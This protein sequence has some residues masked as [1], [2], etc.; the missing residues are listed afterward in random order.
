MRKTV[1]A[2]VMLVS[3]AS[4]AAAQADA[5]VFRLYQGAQELGREVFQDDGTTLRSTVT[6]PLLTTKLVMEETRAGGRV[7]RA[8]LRALAL[9]ADT[10]LRTYTATVEGDSVRLALVPVTGEARRWAKPGQPDGIGAEQSVASI[11]ALIQK[12]GRRDT[13]WRYWLPSADSVLQLQ[14]DFTG[15]SVVVRLASQEMFA[16]LGPDGRVQL[17]EIAASRVRFVR[18]TGADSL[19]PLAGMRRPGP[20]Y[21]APAGAAYTAEQVRVTVRPAAGD[22][23]GLG[24]TLTKPRRGGP[25]FPAAITLTGSGSQDRDENLWP[26][27]PDYRLFRDVAVRLAA[28]GIAVL[29]CD[30][31]GFGASGGPVERATMVDFAEDARARL[32]WLRA[33]PDIDP[34]RLA[35]I[36]HSEGGIVGPMVA[37]DDRRLAALVLM[38][39]TGKDMEAVV[40]DQ[41]L[42]AADRATNLTAEQR[43]A[44]R[45]EALRQADEFLGRPM[46]YLQHARHYDPLVTARLVRQPVLILQGAL[47]RQVTAGQA[48]TLAAAIREGGNRAVTVRVFPGLNHLFLVSPSGTG[49]TDEYAV[50]R[51]VTP[52][53]E[54][55]ETLASWLAARLRAR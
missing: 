33:R 30:D 20:D 27:V 10:L 24:C 49:S 22:T 6:I 25:R 32:A 17:L 28:A 19:P 39:G 40:R 26:L 15:D 34:E 14:L 45:E 31:R 53:A 11:V 36:G 50:L 16:L 43:A 54:V 38:A 42:S 3:I 51:D 48:D 46:P 4:R 21:N 55:L 47:D 23:F 44:A 13:T 29:R 12:A 7:A 37:L 35:V 2:A 8:E 41:F 5:G 52:P 9:P 1:L 18:H